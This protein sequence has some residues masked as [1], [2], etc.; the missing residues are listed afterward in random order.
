MIYLTLFAVSF[1]AATF[2]PIPS[3]VLF[4]YELTQEGRS[5]A[6]L[7]FAASAGNT[8]GSFVNYGIGRFAMDWAL[9]R[10][11]MKQKAL[12]KGHHMME[13]Y[14]YW[15]LLLTWAPVIGGPIMFAAGAARLTWWKFLIVVAIA[16]TLRYGALA[17]GVGAYM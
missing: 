16:K 1:G 8:L 5:L 14:G 9:R 7:L 15:A 10:G 11:Y 6:L 2:I 13:R 3:E 17:I 12:D 4:A